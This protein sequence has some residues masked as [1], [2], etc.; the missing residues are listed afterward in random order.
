[1]TIHRVVFIRPGETDWNRQR[2]WQGWVAVPLNA[3]GRRQAQRLAS[4]IRN[5]G[6]TALYTSDLRRAL[7][8]AGLV[9]EKLGIKP[10]PDE[11]LRER[12]IGAWQG[13]TM[14]EMES[15]YPDQYTQ[16]LA[17]PD[18]YCIPGGESRADVRNRMLAVFQDILAEDRDETIGIITHTTAMYVL[19]DALLPGETKPGG[20]V[21]NTSVTTIVRQPDGN[22]T[23]VAADDVSHLEG[24]EAQTSPELERKP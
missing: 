12:A 9:S 5:I 19:L 11:R 7:D 13:L 8:T 18:R 10:V 4:F 2:R 24:L 1:M 23:L 6:I 14:Q 16:L 21:S 22:W 3:H 20:G 15:W 17:D